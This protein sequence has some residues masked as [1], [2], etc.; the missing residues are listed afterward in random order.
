MQTKSSGWSSWNKGDWRRCK[1]SR[2]RGDQRRCKGQMWCL[3]NIYKRTR[4][5]NVPFYTSYLMLVAMSRVATY[6]NRVFVKVLHR[7]T[8]V[9]NVRGC[10]TIILGGVTYK[11]GD[12]FDSFVP[13]MVDD[14]INASNNVLFVANGG[15][16][17][18]T[19]LRATDVNNDVVL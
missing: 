1:G 3:I 14:N 8:M 12:D 5:Y 13:L 19:V 17:G 2:C 18:D 6:G 9:G 11:G 10:R 4:N 7:R 16:S 15:N